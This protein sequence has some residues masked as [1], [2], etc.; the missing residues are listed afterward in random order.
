MCNPVSSSSTSRPTHPRPATAGSSLRQG[1]CW[2]AGALALTMNAQAADVKVRVL[3]KVSGE[4]AAEA[5][6]CLGTTAQ[7]DQFGA[8]LT[9]GDGTVVFRNVPTTTM[10]LTVS[11]RGYM[12]YQGIK[13]AAAYDRVFVVP[14]P[15]GGLGPQCRTAGPYE[16]VGAP[17]QGLYVGGLRINGGRAVTHDRTVTL[18]ARLK[19]QP[20][21]YRASE[22]ADLEAAQWRPY[23]EPIHLEL[24][25]GSGRKTVYFQV[26][27]YRKL[28]GASLQSTSNVVKASIRLE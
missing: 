10:A 18:S 16:G 6:V 13:A 23:R 7:P 2:L 19:G 5:A 15:H 17:A 1:A 28:N 24:S 25:P 20:T 21:E 4:P 26:R 8:Y 27:K 3:D 14:L 12:G 11:K 9:P 22:Q